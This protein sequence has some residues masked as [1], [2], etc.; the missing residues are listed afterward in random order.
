M[1]ECV[2]FFSS[3]R[4]H[5]RCALVTG[6]Q[7]CALPIYSTY[8]GNVCINRFIQI[9]TGNLF[10]G[11]KRIAKDV[12]ANANNDL[13]EHAFRMGYLFGEKEYRF[14][15][16]TAL[17]RNLTPAQLAWKQKINSRIISKTIVQQRRAS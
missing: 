15:K 7:T 5:T 2:C 3:R 10:E 14:L 16:Q 12:S 6:V 17:K 1:C 9:D 8:V 11:L 4:R 13:I